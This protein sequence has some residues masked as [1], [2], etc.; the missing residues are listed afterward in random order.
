MLEGLYPTLP[1]DTRYFD[2][3]F[4]DELLALFDD[5]ESHIDGVLL[6]SENFQALN[7]LQ[8]KYRKKIKCIYIDPPYNTGADGFLYRD[9]F[10]HSSWLSLMY[11]R[12]LLSRKIAQDNSSIAI[13]INEE[14]LFNLKLLLDVA[15]GSRNYLT[16]LTVKVRHDD[17]IL[18]GDKDVHEVTEQLLV[19]RNSDD[20][21]PTKRVL[22]NTSNDEYR[23]QVTEIVPSKRGLKF[24]GQRGHVI[25][26]E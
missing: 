2:E 17:R 18:T 12:L 16:T 23:W 7:L 8:E 22:D 14:E 21:V 10:R 3:S 19:Y 1:L 25:R 9:S 6:N 5:L 20:F 4:V 13:S 26:T 15:M 24:R 11:D